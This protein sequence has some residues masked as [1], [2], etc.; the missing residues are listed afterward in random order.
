MK[1][2]DETGQI[3]VA[4]IKTCAP[5]VGVVETLRSQRNPVGSPAI[6]AGLFLF[7]VSHSK[8]F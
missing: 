8:P 4:A 1:R 7:A 6:R 3:G 2:D 5:R